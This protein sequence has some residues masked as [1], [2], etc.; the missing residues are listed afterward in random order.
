MIQGQYRE[1]GVYCTRY[2]YVDVFV[3]A[4]E[5]PTQNLERHGPGLV[6]RL[7]FRFLYESIYGFKKSEFMRP[8]VCA[9]T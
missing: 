1:S 9:Q 8:D 6:P 2:L 7:L 3:A 5:S 4:L